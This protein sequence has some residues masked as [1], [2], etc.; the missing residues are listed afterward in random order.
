MVTALLQKSCQAPLRMRTVQRHAA[1]RCAHC[2]NL[3]CQGRAGVRP[4]RVSNYMGS[5]GI[6][7]VSQLVT[8]LTVTA[9][10]LWMGRELLMDQAKI[11]ETPETPCPSCGGTGYERCICTRWSDGDVGCASCKKTGM[12]KC[13]SCGGG[14]TA[15]PIALAVRK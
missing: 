9:G 10:V 8:T 7:T 2:P 12:M 5:V 11:Q 3:H 1:E 15:V 4:L 6:D 13:R 14:G